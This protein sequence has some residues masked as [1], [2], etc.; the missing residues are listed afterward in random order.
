M[1]TLH[2][3]LLL[4]LTGLAGLSALA[5]ALRLNPEGRA[6][7]ALLTFLLFWGAIVFPIF[8][9]GYL[10]LLY[11]TP[12]ALLSCALSVGILG[13]CARGQPLQKSLA[14]LVRA[15]C[16]LLKL[17]PD[18]VKLCWRAK[19]FSLL[20]VLAAAGAIAFTLFLSYVAP[21][22]ES[23]DGLYYHQPI[24]GFA[25]Q[26]HS[27]GL[28]ELPNTLLAQTINGYPKF[29][30]AFSLWFVLFTDKTL[31]EI[32]SSLA[33]PALMLAI[34]LLARRYTNDRPACM[35]WA[36]VVLLMPA[37]CSQLRTTMIDVELW[38]FALCALYLIT[39]PKFRTQDAAL[40]LIATAWVVGTKSTGLV[41]APPLIAAVAWRSLQ[42]EDR[43]AVLPWL[44]PG[45]VLIGTFGAL[46]FLRNFRAFHNPFWPVS[47]ASNALSIDFRG[48]AK[49]RQL[50]PDPNF[51]DLFAREYEHPAGGV[52]DIIFRSYG[53]A[54][55]WVVLPLGAL[56]LLT[57]V[58]VAAKGVAL[59]ARDTRAE[60]LLLVAIITLPPFL[61]S[62]SFANARYNI[63]LVVTALLA[64]AWAGGRW[65]AQRL[66]EGA[67]ASSLMLSLMSFVWSGFLW[68]LSL[69]W[70][71]IGALVTHSRAERASM[72][73]S[74]FQM[75]A[76][77]A[78]LRE[79]ELGPGDV[80]AFTSDLSFIGV[81][82]NDAFSNRVVYLSSGDRALLSELARL[83]ARWVAVGERSAA[84]R[85]LDKSADYEFVG[86]AAQQDKSV[87]FR[88]HAR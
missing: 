87:I 34:Y 44:L 66:Q 83:N 85:T 54:I 37:L 74:S 12:V 77:V 23:W 61:M 29:G 64:I 79:A 2:W 22:D 76:K 58:V 49:L 41:L 3:L 67:V 82:W 15:A 8:A 1:E 45:L 9:L 71:D 6:E 5:L 63:Q 18:G 55:P 13:V 80:A 81:L 73:F 21:A 10:A 35:G 39:K 38:F 36:A 53:Q 33:A 51:A 19:S 4:A 16:D 57:C 17:A 14:T 70:K 72:N 84:R 32:G 47:Y 46:T 65:P 24:V 40:A 27:F 88:R 48:L 59:R 11:R 26:N 52:H 43:R 56:S 25:L 62:P 28:V 68:G 69:D 42:Q 30:E 7:T 50:S 20:G 78:R 75:P 86:A 31:I 60:N